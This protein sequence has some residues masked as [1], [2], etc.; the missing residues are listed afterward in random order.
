[1]T[2]G[3]DRLLENLAAFDLRVQAAKNGD[4]TRPTPCRGWTAE[5]VVNHVMSN[6]RK[7]SA[8]LQ[9]TAIELRLEGEGIVAA[10]DRTFAMAKSVLPGADTSVSISGAMGPTPAEAIIEGPIA[11]DALV[12]TW[13]LARAVGGDEE[14][15][16]NAVE[17]AYQGIKMADVMLRRPRVMG[18]KV[19]SA[20]DADLQTEFLNFVG[21]TV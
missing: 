14:L 19:T 10:W 18:P 15:D 16:R 3:T 20:P 17:F 6:I 2:A 4:W 9:G 5:H 21:R 7:L 13:D 12:H 11:T 1:M 8:N